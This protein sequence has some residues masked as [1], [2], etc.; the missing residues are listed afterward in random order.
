MFD[1][2]HLILAWSAILGLATAARAVEKSPLVRRY[3]L[4]G[5]ISDD[6]G[7]NKLDGIAVIKD[8]ESKVTLTIKTGQNLPYSPLK[9]KRIERQ[10]VVLQDGDQLYDVRHEG[11]SEDNSKS[12]EIATKDMLD[13]DLDWDDWENFINNDYVEEESQS[14][15]ETRPGRSYPSADLPLLPSPR[16]AILDTR[17]I[18]VKCDANGCEEELLNPEEVTE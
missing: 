3:V 15:I 11:T 13:S 10:L 6:T 1:V 9:V 12:E 17:S 8:L 16:R 2:R 14:E 4:I 7:K 18:R 5:V